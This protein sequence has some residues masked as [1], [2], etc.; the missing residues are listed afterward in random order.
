M[1]PLA[2]IY[3]P[4]KSIKPTKI[5]DIEITPIPP[6]EAVIEL[7]RYSFITPAIAEKMGW[8]PRRLDF[9][10][11]LVKQVPVKRLMYPSGLEHLPRV[12]EA[13]LQDLKNLTPQSTAS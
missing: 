4:S 10:S 11:R 1:R 13:V 7:V 12:T 6:S 3:I 8:Q 9:F 2:C 5:L